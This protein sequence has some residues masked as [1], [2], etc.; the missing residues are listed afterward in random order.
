MKTLGISEAR[1]LN[2]KTILENLTG[3]LRLKRPCTV[4]DGIERLSEETI[5][6]LLALQEEAA[7]KGRFVKF[8]PASGAATRMFQKLLSVYHDP[9]L[10]DFPHSE[11]ISEEYDPGIKELQN[12]LRRLDRFAFFPELK[13]V[14]ARDGF[15]FAGLLGKG[16]WRKVLDY[17]L[18]NL[19]LNYLHRPKGMHTF[20]SYKD[21][22]R[23]A[24]EE[25]LVEAVHTVCDAIHHCRLHV[26]IAPEHEDTFR[27]FFEFLRR[28]YETR[29]NCSFEVSIS[30]QSHETDVLAVD[31]D[32]N[33]LRREDGTLLFRPGGHG[34]LL[35]NLNALRGDL[36]YI[37]NIDNILPD[38]L[39]NPVVVWKKILGGYLVEIERSVHAFVRKLSEGTFSPGL[40]DEA[41]SFGQ[42]R[43]NLSEPPE[44]QQR[45]DR[46][47]K[48]YWLDLLNRPIRV[49]GMVKNSG[50]PGGGPFWVEGCDGYC[51]RQIVESAQ[52][53]VTSPE[54]RALWASSTH[55]NPVDLVC[56]VRNY[57]NQPFNLDHYKDDEAVFITKK[58]Y[59][60]HDLKALELP[61]L[62]N[63]GMARWLTLFV[64]V[65]DQTFAPV[66]TINDLLKPNHL[67]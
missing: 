3:Y 57:Q 10:N 56:A 12:F 54:Q 6:S 60:G 44:V 50:E 63:G 8:V 66:K 23:T 21:H 47:K 67:P 29:Y 55:F 48:A 33:P 49:C 20:H 4:G 15:E 14:L 45:S 9:T 27:G 38:R 13:A 18:T 51:S 16:Q 24:F 61:G 32:N 37:K 53:E 17:L 52:I 31:F 7:R 30:C 11:D 2:Q 64:E 26:T 34:A 41:R 22:T 36:I 43:L 5:P 58:S 39:K 46:G 25:H 65:P 28:D 59:N 1:I 62:W 40:L 42:N 19:G 35:Q